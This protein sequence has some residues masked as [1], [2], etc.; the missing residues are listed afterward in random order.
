PRAAAERMRARMF[1]AVAGGYTGASRSRRQT[2]QWKY[3]K[4]QSADSD[5]LPDLPELRDRSR[6]LVRNE[7]IAAGAVGGAVTSVV[8]TGLALQ[9]RVDH[10]VLRM[11]EEQAEDWQK[12]TEREFCLWAE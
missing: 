2:S 9:S 11:T 7:P 5:I 6:D 3:T 8:G 10:E 1:M 4:G 12:Q